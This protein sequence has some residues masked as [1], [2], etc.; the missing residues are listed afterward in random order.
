ML[1]PIPC[2]ENPFKLKVTVRALMPVDVVLM[3]EDAYLQDS[4]YFSRKVSFDAKK[5]RAGNDTRKITLSLPLSPKLLLVQ[6]YNAKSSDDRAFE[7]ENIEVEK[8][9][10]PQL[11]ADPVTHRYIEFAKDFAKNMGTYEPGFYRSKSGEFLIELVPVI[12]DEN[13]KELITPARVNR[14]TGRKQISQKA[15]LR[16]SIPIRVF[17]LMHEHAHFHLPTRS[18]KVADLSGLKYYLD[19]QFPKIEAV[20]AATK[21]FDLHPE[22]VTWRH[23]QRVM[24]IE[25]FIDAYGAEEKKTMQNYNTQR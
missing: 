20:Y 25:D 23:E 8:F 22:N 13:G 2:K 9:P 15:F 11:W 14:E 12:R 3:G 16:L 17:I 24:D 18:E 6:V 5:L 4:V 1:V 19:M 7:V 21:V 10:P